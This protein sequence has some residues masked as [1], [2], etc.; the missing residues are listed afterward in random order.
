MPNRVKTSM[1]NSVKSKS[2]EP[3]PMRVVFFLTGTQLPQIKSPRHSQWHI[4]AILI[5]SHTS[6]EKPWF[7]SSSWEL[8]L[9]SASWNS[10]QMR[11]PHFSLP[12]PLPLHLSL[13]WPCWEGG[14]LDP[15]F[16]TA[17]RSVRRLAKATS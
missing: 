14:K 7:G 9:G 17:V 10:V 13:P 5:T 6:C 8:P 3:W 15:D 4:V 11:F 16:G 12:V 2:C 1:P